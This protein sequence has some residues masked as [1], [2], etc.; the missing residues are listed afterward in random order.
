MGAP[1]RGLRGRKNGNR[2]YHFASYDF[3]PPGSRAKS[4]REEWHAGGTRCTAQHQVT[5][6]ELVG[7]RWR[8]RRN[9]ARPE[10]QVRRR[11]T[12]Y[13]AEE[14]QPAPS[15]LAA[16]AKS[17]MLV[18]NRLAHAFHGLKTLRA[19][20]PAVFP[21]EPA[22]AKSPKRSKFRVPSESKIALCFTH[23]LLTEDQHAAHRSLNMVPRGPA[24]SGGA[25]GCQRAVRFSGRKSA[26]R[27]SPS[28][29]IAMAR[30]PAYP[31]RKPWIKCDGLCSAWDELGF[32]SGCTL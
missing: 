29:R 4:V 17:V 9:P 22:F 12:E 24:R 11:Q 30:R 8:A 19:V 18:S 10:A 25:F 20:L 28:P 27:G 31:D 16:T 15:R 5:L 2:G 23:A 6:F 3:R 7:N 21:S 32:Q 14:M 1:N 26:T 13:S